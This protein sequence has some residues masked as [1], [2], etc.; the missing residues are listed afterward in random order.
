MHE[1]MGWLHVYFS[2]LNKN[3]ESEGANDGRYYISLLG[4][5][6]GPVPIRRKVAMSIDIF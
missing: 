6:S 1:E 2:H 3:R 5:C 4:C